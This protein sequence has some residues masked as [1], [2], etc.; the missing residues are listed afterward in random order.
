MSHRSNTA[1]IRQVSA[2]EW[3]KSPW[4][5]FDDVKLCVT[6]LLLPCYQGAVNKAVIDERECNVC[7]CCCWSPN[8]E[9]F[10]RQQI[11]AKYGMQYEHAKDCLLLSFCFPCMMC[12]NG[13]EIRVREE[14][15]FPSGY[16]V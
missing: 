14:R 10:T 6:T 3:I 9:Y 1:S 8:L 12:Q 7:D 15:K 5:C 13:L 16:K 4:S 11:R 2:S